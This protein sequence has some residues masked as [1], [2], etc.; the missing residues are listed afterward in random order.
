M[1]P[2]SRT[3]VDRRDGKYV[4][5]KGMTVKKHYFYFA[6]CP[7][8]AKKYGHNYVLAFTEVKEK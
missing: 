1:V 5:E 8:Y 4:S 6:Y 3:R 7:K 2:I